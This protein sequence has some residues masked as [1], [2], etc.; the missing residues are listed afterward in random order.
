MTEPQLLFA[1][2]TAVFLFLMAAIV[3]WPSSRKG[4]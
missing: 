4:V 3:C 2:V 1:T